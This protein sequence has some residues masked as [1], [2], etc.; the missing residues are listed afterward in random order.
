MGVDA[1]RAHCKTHAEGACFFQHFGVGDLDLACDAM[2]PAKTAKVKAFQTVLLAD[3]VY[4]DQDS[5]PYTKVLRTHARY[6]LSL[7]FTGRRLFP[8]TLLFSFAMIAVAFTVRS[9]VFG[10]K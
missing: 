8:H 5:Q 7:V 4:M 1:D 2:D 9:R 10:I 6:T 3:V